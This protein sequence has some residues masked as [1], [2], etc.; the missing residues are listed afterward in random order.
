[1]TAII[2]KKVVLYWIM[3]FKNMI[4]TWKNISERVAQI[5]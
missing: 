5:S 1:M 3:L 4:L 2:T